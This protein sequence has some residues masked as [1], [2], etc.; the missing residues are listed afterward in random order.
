V[1]DLSVQGDRRGGL[2]GLVKME[3]N[4]SG[5][6]IAKANRGGTMEGGI[7]IALIFNGHGRSSCIRFTFQV[8]DIE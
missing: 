3:I 6:G 7:V 8:V 1:G 2:I 5:R 4:L